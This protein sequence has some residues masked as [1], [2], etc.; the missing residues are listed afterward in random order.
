MQILRTDRE[1]LGAWLQPAPGQPITGHLYLVDPMGRW[2]WRSPPKADPQRIKRD[3]DRL[4]RA[5]GS[6]DKPGRQP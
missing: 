4:L 5:A 1:A 3:L 6:W 2:M